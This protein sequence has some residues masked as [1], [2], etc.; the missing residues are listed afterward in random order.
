MST[1]VS[2]VTAVAEVLCEERADGTRVLRVGEELREYPP[3]LGHALRRWAAECPERTLAAERDGDGWRR[4]T[5]GEA[6]EAAAAVGQAFLERGYGPHAPV[7]LLSG[8]SLDHLV[9]TLAGYLTGVPVVPVSVAYSVRSTDHARLRA[10]AALVRPGLVYADDGVRFRS[11]LDAAAVAAGTAPRT[12]VSHSPTAGDLTVGALRN[13]VVTGAVDRAFESLSPDTVAK[14]LFTSGSTGGPKGVLNTHRMLCAN[15]QM[16]RQAWS[17]LESE[18]PTLTDWL[19]WSHTFGGNHNLHLALCNGGT[20]HIDDGAPLPAAFERTVDALRVIPPS[21]CVNVPAGYAL[22]AQR[23]ESDPALARQVLSR[24]RVIM[25][26]GADLPDALRRR[27]HAVARSATGR[28]VDIVSSWGATETG[29]AATSTYGGV[30]EGIGIPLPGVEL[31]LVPLDGRAELRVRSASVAPGYLGAEMSDAVDEEGYYRTGDAARL[32]DPGDPR[33]GLV[34]DGRTAEDFKLANGTWV[35]TGRLRNALLSAA[36]VL[37]DV[38]L[39]GGDREHVAAIAWPAPARANEL[40]GTRATDP[41]E[42]V[43]HVGLRRHLAGVLAALNRGG[44]AASRVERLVLVAEPPSI[45]DGEITDKGYLNQRRVTER[46]GDVVD[47]LY[48]ADPDPARV[49]TAR[50]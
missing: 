10:I 17:F 6:A 32:L 47:L 27:L 19:P 16:I 41:A 22:L 18:P 4:L 33:R 2:A 3:T 46:R 35:V 15:Q 26:A 8:N 34:F 44:G 28:D 1:A 20:L 9:L 38:V 42:L 36:G 30:R 14:I 39:V 48:A 50:E 12:L 11:A 13:T 31:K 45:D 21:V 43:G 49:V 25:Y 40:L 24:I 7:L 37:S 5:Y 23:L 29:P